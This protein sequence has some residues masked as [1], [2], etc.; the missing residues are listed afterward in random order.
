MLRENRAHIKKFYQDLALIVLNTIVVFIILNIL[1]IPY[2]YFK[3]RGAS[4]TS[5]CCEGG[6]FFN[7][8]G[9]PRDNGKR[10][11]VML[12]QFDYRGYKSF[13]QS[14][15]A[16]VLDDF[17]F[18]TLRGYDYQPWVQFMQR[19][20]KS[21]HVN[22]IQDEWGLP[23][24]YTPTS[25]NVENFPVVRIFVFGG[26]TTFGQFVAD[27]HTWP[28]FLQEILSQQVR[29]FGYR[30]HIQVYNY[31][32]NYYYP[33]QEMILFL[34][35]LRSGHR[36]GLAIFMDG[37]NWGRA[38]DYP[39]LTQEFEERFAKVQFS[40]SPSL[41]QRLD[42]IPVIKFVLLLKNKETGEKKATPYR[43]YKKK[44][45]PN[46]EFIR[47][48]V[49]NRFQQSLEITKR[50][51]DYYN[52]QTL[53]FLQ[54]NA[55]IDADFER[56]QLKGKKAKIIESQTIAKDLYATLK[57]DTNYIYLED[58]FTQWGPEKFALIDQAHY[59]PDFAR[60]LAGEVAKQ[61]DLS[62][63]IGKDNEF[64]EGMAT[65]LK[66]ESSIILVE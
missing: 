37:L 49:I 62:G 32:R 31:G 36:P 47:S 65:G 51:G 7:D 11:Y 28:A 16:E 6:V 25:P 24:R 33:T 12:T 17:Y 43:K 14:Y 23:L 53:F 2:N 29:N 64:A 63:L 60:F 42:W 41:L 19:P 39:S 22:I 46:E 20:Y 50:I 56:I 38:Q 48:H 3:E 61:I 10:T 27:E 57:N 4:E 30:V 45:I 8:D 15:V 18:L 13:P 55:V 59:G 66:R 44:K 54:P 9:T 26:S 35:L 34:D 40:Q 5:N 21:K 52:V 58:L 1:F